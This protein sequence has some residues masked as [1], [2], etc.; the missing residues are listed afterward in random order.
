MPVKNYVKERGDSRFKQRVAK[1]WNK[2]GDVIANIPL[3]PGTGIVDWFVTRKVLGQPSR[4]E[5]QKI[6]DAHK[7][8]LIKAVKAST[9]GSA[10]AEM[11][12]SAIK[13][14]DRAS[15]VNRNAPTA[16]LMQIRPLEPNFTGKG[17]KSFKSWDKTERA[18]VKH[19]FNTLSKL[20]YER[21]KAERLKV[22]SPRRFQ[23]ELRKP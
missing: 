2:Y 3:V 1:F 14:V 15:E 6:L 10:K 20:E 5:T 9:N 4:E 22:N 23:P 8:M 19:V 16:R 7:K 11:Y 12:E 18:K 13:Q 17:I 21:R